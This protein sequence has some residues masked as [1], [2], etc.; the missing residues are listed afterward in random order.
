VRAAVR[1]GAEIRVGDNPISQPINAIETARAC[2]FLDVCAGNFRNINL[3]V[4]KVR[5]PGREVRET[6][7]ARD[8]LETELLI[9]VPRFKVH[10]LT[11]L[12][13]AVKNHYGII[14]G[15][16]KLKHHFDSSTLAEFCR[17]II[18]VYLLRPPDLVIVD[19]LRARDGLGRLFAPNLLIAGTDGFSVDYACHL[20]A[21]SRAVK[22]VVLQTAIRD[23]RF[24][25]AA[26]EIIG[27]LRPLKG[28]RLP[29]TFPL[30]NILAGI[31]QR[32][33]GRLRGGRRPAFD[34]KRCNR[35]GACENICPARAIRDY[36]IDLRQCVRCYCCI[37]VCP[38][39]AMRRKFKL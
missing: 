38:R 18:D 26:V 5:L 16:L 22:D 4:K 35:C 11:V 33:F 8:I 28:F 19:C 9:S 27:D 13:G 39:A 23:G 36:R 29:F 6:W 31:G 3:Y 20:L 37:E 21:G 15:D 34:F 2:G 1:R 24:D 7:I 32:V 10:P 17:L 30:R 25:P 12:S 14:A